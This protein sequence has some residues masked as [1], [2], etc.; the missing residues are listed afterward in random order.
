MISNKLFMHG[1]VE[2][3]DRVGSS[4][5]RQ[6]LFISV[7][8]SQEFLGPQLHLLSLEERDKI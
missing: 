7:P 5:R 2:E 4:G 3:L 1:A 8:C 6:V